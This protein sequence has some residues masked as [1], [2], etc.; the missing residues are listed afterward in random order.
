MSMKNA[1]RDDT[2]TSPS[3][4]LRESRLL[5]EMVLSSS[6]Q[7]SKS[8]SKSTRIFTVALSCLLLLL[9]VPPT[10]AVRLHPL[11]QDRTTDDADNGVGGH[12]VLN[13]E[14]G[15]FEFSTLSSSSSFAANAN[16][17]ANASE[18]TS[19]LPLPLSRTLRMPTDPSEHLVTSLPLLNPQDFTSPHWAGHLPASA[20][21]DKY[22]FYWLFAPDTTAQ[23]E[24]HPDQDIPII[25]WLNGGPGCSSMDGL[26]LENGPLRFEKENGEYKLKPNEHSWHKTPA[27]TL[28]IDQPVGTG[29]SFTK[30]KKYAHDDDAV[31]QDFYFFLQSFFTLHADK[32]VAQSPRPTVRRPLFFS[33]ESHAGHYIPSMMA[34]ILKQNGIVKAD[35][36]VIPLAGAAIGNGWTDP[37]HQY[38]AAEAAYGHGIIGRAQVAALAIKEKECQ[39]R[40][41]AG[42]FTA[43][44]CFSL[45][46]KIIDQSHGS[47]SSYK[48]S[49]YDVRKSE[50][51]S[52]S[53]SFPPGHKVVEAYLGDW[54]LAE[55]GVPPGIMASVLEALHATEATTSKQ[56]FQ[57]C[58]DPPYNALSHQDGKGVVPEL[59]Q[60]LQHPQKPRILFFNGI[61]DLICNHVG[62][63]K[64]LEVLP[65]KHRDEWIES[66]R[67]GWKATTEETGKVSG[68]MKEYENLMFLKLMGSGHMVP[69]DVPNVA[70][71]MMRA[72]CYGKSFDTNKQRLDS[73]KT[74]SPTCDV[75]PTCDDGDDGSGSG[76]EVKPSETNPSANASKTGGGFFISYSWLA[77]LLAGGAVAVVLETRRQ[78]QWASHRP[79]AAGFDMELRETHY[80][81][82]ADESETM[83]GNG[84][85]GDSHEVI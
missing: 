67:Y 50:L 58:T 70:L 40:L 35:S 66:S 23:T 1:G 53:R 56:R 20:T 85:N 77:L 43:S 82:D 21:D 78:R 19:P 83:N 59:V 76:S 25:I 13:E 84:E 10:A 37:I 2:S 18:M 72:F 31:D 15:V 46:D 24:T 54:E 52:G 11:D 51:T 45:L 71:D 16:A 55:G 65:W 12:R 27:F 44:V 26:F 63:E 79:L 17:N 81:D 73:A 74:T 34:Y 80:T 60:V 64:F 36:I 75:C 62:N 14:K 28:Y 32:F 41:R 57:E 69:L 9:T 61:E 3:P 49:M 5:P 29:L 8:T 68:Y 42:D 47:G 39:D 6:S 30:T 4:R 48:V 33:G 38:A 7:K 22:L